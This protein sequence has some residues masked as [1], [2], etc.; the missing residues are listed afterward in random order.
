MFICIK[1]KT[2]S[3]I[4]PYTQ[5][6]KRCGETCLMFVRNPMNDVVIIIIII[7]VIIKDHTKVYYTNL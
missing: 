6:D 7:F 2:T 4:S 3:L 5:P 1:Q